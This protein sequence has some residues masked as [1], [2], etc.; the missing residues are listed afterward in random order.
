MQPYAFLSMLLLTQET[1]LK[2]QLHDYIEE[3][4]SEL[5]EFGRL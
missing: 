4:Q 5:N 3:I 1:K 2:K